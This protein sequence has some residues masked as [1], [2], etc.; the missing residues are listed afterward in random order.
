VVSPL[1]LPHSHGFDDEIR[2][3]DRDRHSDAK[4]AALAVLGNGNGLSGT[5]NGFGLA[6][7]L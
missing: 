2:Y 5:W 1:G 3:L 6:E 4:D 7:F